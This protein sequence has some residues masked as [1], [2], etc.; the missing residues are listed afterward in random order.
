MS[1]AQKTHRQMEKNRRP[2]NKPTEL[3]P[4]DLWWKCQKRVGKKTASSINGV[5]ETGHLH[6]EDLN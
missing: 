1:L 3:Q 5:E 2:R 6:V 4:S